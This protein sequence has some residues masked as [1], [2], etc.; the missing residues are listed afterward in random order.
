[1][2]GRWK[3][4][5]GPERWNAAMFKTPCAITGNSTVN[6]NAKAPV[7]KSVC[8]KGTLAGRR[9]RDGNWWKSVGTAEGIVVE[10]MYA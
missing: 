1:M 2:E 8:H 6:H 4:G 9:G 5:R 7:F 10:T 3:A